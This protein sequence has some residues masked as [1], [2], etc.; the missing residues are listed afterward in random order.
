M[1][2]GLRHYIYNSSVTRRVKRVY[3]PL[4]GLLLLAYFITVQL[5]SHPADDTLDKL[6]PFTDRKPIVYSDA[7]NLSFGGLENLHP[8]DSQKYGSVHASLIASGHLAA[9]DFIPAAKPTEAQ[10]LLA[11]DAGYLK[12]LES[13]RFLANVMELH[14][15]RVIPPALNRNL[16]LEPMLYQMGGSLLAAQAALRHGWGINLGGGF[17]HASRHKGEGFCPLADISLIIH[18]LRALGHIKT[19]MIVDLDAHQ[20]NGHGRD[21]GEDENVFILDIYN[22]S[23]YPDDRPA[24]K[25][26]DK[27]VEL[28]A[29]TADAQYLAA[30]EQALQQSFAEF[31]PDIVIYIAGTDILAGDRLGRMDISAEAIAKRDE[32]VF[33]EA[34]ARDI[35][36]VMLLAGGYQQN[37]AAVIAESLLNLRKKF[38]LF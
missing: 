13:S 25:G 26:I 12:K 18:Q 20:G 34:L 31:Q 10:L 16:L 38:Q 6:P 28:P 33:A 30:V 22:H 15:L 19:A 32:L 36:I 8:F 2:H 37:N 17:H 14:I 9:D 24:K 4:A 27:Q 11:H 5:T 35:P 23:I 21:F 7:Y 29:Y 3:L 1:L